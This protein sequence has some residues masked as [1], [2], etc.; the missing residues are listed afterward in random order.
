M[1]SSVQEL[2]GK[3]FRRLGLENSSERRVASG[4]SGRGRGGRTAGRGSSRQE[5]RKAARGERKNRRY[6]RSDTSSFRNAHNSQPLTR[7]EPG[8]ESRSRIDGSIHQYES[9]AEAAESVDS[10]ELHGEE[11]SIDSDEYIFGQ[12]NG[13][14]SDQSSNDGHTG[15]TEESSDSGANK[16]AQARL[17][18]D[19]AEIDDYE[20]KLGIKG[21]KTLP[22]SFQE[23]GLG[24]LFEGFDDEDEAQQTDE[25]GAK[26]R[27]RDDHDWLAS[28]RRKAVLASQQ[29]KGAT[30]DHQRDSPTLAK[31][32]ENADVSD[33]D[34][35][36]S[37]P[38]RDGGSEMHAQR[39][40]RENPYKAPTNEGES[41]KYVPPA[42]RKRVSENDNIARIRRQVQGLINRLT[43]N[44]MLSIVGSMRGL[45]E[46]NPRGAVTEA[47]TSAILDQLCKPET[48]PDQFFV[49]SGG[50]CAA[51]YKVTGSSFGS[52]MINEIVK[53]FSRVYANSL[54][55]L[56]T[57]AASEIPKEPSNIL[58]FLTQLYTF[59]VVSCRL[60]FDFMRR[61]LEDL[62]EL[63]VELLLRICRMAGPML[64][65]DD[66]DT[67]NNVADQLNKAL[68]QV[69]YETS[70]RTKFMVETI[71]GL[72]SRKKK[73]RGLDSDV[74]SEAVRR[75]NKRL[76]ELKAQTRRLDGQAPMGMSLN[77]I[78]GQDSRGKWWLVGA[79]V[80]V[81]DNSSIQ[82][83]ASA[84]LQA[85]SS[86]AL[87]DEDFESGSEDIS[88]FIPNFAEKARDQGFTTNTD[89][90]IFT[91]IAGA[92]SV[93]EGYA[94]FQNLRLKKNERSNLASILVQ[95]SG[96]E[97]EYN[98]YYAQLAKV[99]C[100][101]GRT[102]F[103][104]KARFWGILRSLGEQ[105][106]GEDP[107]MEEDNMDT[108]RMQD[109][110]R[111]RNVA[112][113]FADLVHEGSLDLTI[114]KPLEIHAM[115][116]WTTRFIEYFMLELLDGCK[117]SAE[118]EDAAVARV[119][120][121]V[122]ALPILG[123][124]LGWFLREKNIVTRQKRLGPKKMERLQRASHKAQ[125]VLQRVAQGV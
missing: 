19:D 102:R 40:P 83:S 52:H 122:K 7:A 25:E 1:P 74:V 22:K 72:R 112:M 65:R 60:I 64:R 63:N 8:K 115:T 5:Q 76:G 93:S 89:V 109:S 56:S 77:D 79:S 99:A 57:A 26:K 36:R 119:F 41:V 114:L 95:C 2:Q 125:L 118:N 15:D 4:P 113:F 84:N 110:R 86:G 3:L 75:M 96:S 123:A 16:V 121:S 107:E 11:G 80:P 68:K 98:E 117:G 97:I 58:A 17:A 87:D 45:Y 42:L 90:A 37:L 30:S 70:V 61:F 103:A 48:M 104:F 67:L 106:F 23:D 62:N 24:D 12:H 78:E 55:V 43:D 34:D 38:P 66:P 88:L 27:K 91:A 50:F 29:T 53:L 94:R 73:A 69:G 47:I 35:L 31:G 59:Q 6:N 39:R 108:V 71:S 92:T 44:N 21:R 18:I 116:V 101:D 20:R 120:G 54:A 49:L 81:R 46:T 100:A 111:L 124:G 9:E 10:E 28:K 14:G 33:E 85:S 32:N 51:L 13:S 82:A 105:L